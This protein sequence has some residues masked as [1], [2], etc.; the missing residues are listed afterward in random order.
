[1]YLFVYST[2]LEQLEHKHRTSGTCSFKHPEHVA[3]IPELSCVTIGALPRKEL[4]Y[5]FGCSNN[6]FQVFGQHIPDVLMAKGPLQ[7]E[8][9]YT[10]LSICK[11]T[12]ITKYDLW[13]LYR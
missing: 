7:L 9:V 5:C 11:F 8:D 6:M 10:F 1:M 2:M 4:S 12:K 13:N 3:R